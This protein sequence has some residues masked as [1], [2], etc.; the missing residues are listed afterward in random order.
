[1]SDPP[2]H[3]PGFHLP[4]T[5]IP[6]GAAAEQQ[7]MQAEAAA[8]DEREKERRRRANLLVTLGDD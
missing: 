1:M 5:L 3:I 2:G 7:R 6:I 8:R 4:G